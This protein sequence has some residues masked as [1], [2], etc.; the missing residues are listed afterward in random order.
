MIKAARNA[1]G[2]GNKKE[3]SLM[4][5]DV[6][7]CDFLADVLEGI[8]KN[9]KFFGGEMRGLAINDGSVQS[10]G[11]P[12]AGLVEIV[13]GD[14]G[15]VERRNHWLNSLLN[16]KLPGLRNRVL[17]AFQEGLPELF[18][19]LFGKL[20]NLRIDFGFPLFVGGRNVLASEFVESFFY[21]HIYRSFKSSP[22][23]DVYR[24]KVGIIN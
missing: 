2:F 14:E 21:S 16:A 24:V 22:C 12:A 17:R 5:W 15:K 20:A 10:L 19:G 3:R 4:N 11:E 18:R 23:G 8:G 13:L 1:D 6:N 7:I 9:F